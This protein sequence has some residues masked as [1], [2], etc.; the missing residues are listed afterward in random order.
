MSK[1]AKKLE[2]TWLDNDDIMIRRPSDDEQR[3]GK[4]QTSDYQI[5]S[6]TIQTKIMSC[7]ELIDRVYRTK[8]T[9]IEKSNSNKIKKYKTIINK[10]FYHLKFVNTTEEFYE[11]LGEDK[12][13]SE[14]IG[15]DVK[16]ILKSQKSWD[17]VLTQSHILPIIVTF[18]KEN[19]DSEEY[20]EEEVAI[21]KKNYV[22]VFNFLKKQSERYENPALYFT[23]LS[24]INSFNS[25]LRE[26]L[27]KDDSENLLDFPGSFEDFKNYV[28]HY[29]ETKNVGSIKRHTQTVVN[30]LCQESQ[31][32]ILETIIEDGIGDM[33]TLPNFITYLEN[34]KPH[35]ISNFQ[36]ECGI[37]I[38]NYSTFDDLCDA[39]Y[40][41]EVIAHIRNGLNVKIRARSTGDIRKGAEL[42]IEQKRFIAKYENAK[43]RLGE[44]ISDYNPENE[45]FNIEVKK[46]IVDEKKEELEQKKIEYEEY[47]EQLHNARSI[48]DSSSVS[49]L[50]NKLRNKEEE[51]RQINRTY[52][53]LK[54][55][56]IESR[57][58][59]KSKNRAYEIYKQYKLKELEMI[60][61]MKDDR[62]YEDL[63]ELDIM[64]QKIKNNLL[65]EDYI[66][67]FTWRFV[68]CDMDI[69]TADTI[70]ESLEKYLNEKN[71]VCGEPG[72]INA[73][74]HQFRSGPDKL[75][76]FFIDYPKSAAIY[77]AF[78]KKGHNLSKILVKGFADCLKKDIKCVEEDTYFNVPMEKTLSNDDEDTFW[79]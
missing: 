42:I 13:L 7:L 24:S 1:E 45:N 19:Q 10:L 15:F 37:D 14:K 36:D 43:K 12:K 49:Y 47:K 50:K 55:D 79:N 23:A 2:K 3:A 18:V 22:A 5:S 21:C 6:L 63:H 20:T 65:D 53:I 77:K 28:F 61:N 62:L 25:I 26:N 54:R 46:K 11:I 67:Y 57:N 38:R 35:I 66:P 58:K 16:L 69:E 75:I 8:L 9:T 73:T 39:L 41:P 74:A 33:L 52:K 17:K 34:H 30:E 71:G 44:D 31:K 56:Y 60:H 64:E 40:A 59:T 48:R 32:E 27:M 72:Y 78:E 29:L 70:C 4:I 51:I 76:Q 68:C